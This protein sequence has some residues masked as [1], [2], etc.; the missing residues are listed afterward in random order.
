MQKKDDEEEKGKKKEGR[1]KRTRMGGEETLCRG[2]MY[3]LTNDVHAVIIYGIVIVVDVID[4]H[5]VVVVID[6]SVGWI[7]RVYG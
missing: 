4:V 2:S 1:S 6:V 3:A 7:Y 5:L